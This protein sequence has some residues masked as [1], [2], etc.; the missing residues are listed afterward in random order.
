MKCT[1][2]IR[3]SG[4]SDWNIR[5]AGKELNMCADDE[6]TLICDD[7]IPGE[8]FIN[9]SQEPTKKMRFFEII[10]LILISAIELIFDL[11]TNSLNLSWKKEV[12]PYYLNAEIKVK[13]NNDRKISIDLRD[14][15]YHGDWYLP[16]VNV[17]NISDENLSIKYSLNLLDF[18][19]SLTH[20]IV[21]L[22]VLIVPITMLMVLAAISTLKELRIFA[23]LF[24]IS[25]IILLSA[26]YVHQ[27]KKLIKSYKHELQAAN[28]KL[29]QFQE[30]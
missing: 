13:I 23:F 19:Q 30:N 21:K 22:S 24:I 16:K 28:D 14:S 29:K 18:R 25:F 11:F 1:L 9:I 7:L 10:F 3:S 15:E 26:F 20:Y 17:R 12:V 8:Y 27:M 6:Q 2:S 5:F 4:C